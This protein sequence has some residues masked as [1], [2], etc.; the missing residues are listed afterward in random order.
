[1]MLSGIGIRWRRFLGTGLPL[2]VSITYDLGVA[3]FSLTTAG[4]F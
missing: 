3:A 4:V 2:L 1:M